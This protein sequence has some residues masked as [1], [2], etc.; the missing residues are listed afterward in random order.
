M[1]DALMARAENPVNNNTTCQG[2]NDDTVGDAGT[3]LLTSEEDMNKMKNKELQ[4][5]LGKQGLIKRGRKFELIA[6]LK[7]AM[8]DRV[9][10]ADDN[11]ASTTNIVSSST[12]LPGFPDEAYWKELIPQNAPVEEPTTPF[13][14]HA[15]TVPKE[16]HFHVP[17]KFHF[18]FT[19]ER[20]AFTGK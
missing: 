16:D 11:A 4:D 1:L 7:K 9:L 18:N 13:Q 2:K 10:I 17:E 15:P 6:C 12:E 8:H 20:K 19:I 3:F 5:E 14:A